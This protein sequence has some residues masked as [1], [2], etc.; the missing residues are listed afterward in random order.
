MSLILSVLSFSFSVLSVVNQK[1]ITSDLNDL[2]STLQDIRSFCQKMP[3]TAEDRFAVV[4]SVSFTKT[5]QRYVCVDDDVRWWNFV[6]LDS[7]VCRTSWK[8]VTQQSSLWS[9]SNR[10]LWRNSA[11]LP[12]TLEKTANPQTL[13][14]SLVSL[15]S[16]SANLRW[17][18]KI[19]LF[20]YSYKSCCPTFTVL[21]PKQS[22]PSFIQFIKTHFF[23]QLMMHNLNGCR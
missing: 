20:I 2:H 21:Q 7:S 14:P 17:A 1:T 18:I 4:M 23:N 9:P 10:E 12:L 3:A 15:L 8:T 22:V 11:K 19:Q 6:P 13:R 16:S 5:A